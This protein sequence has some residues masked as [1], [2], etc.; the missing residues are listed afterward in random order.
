MNSFSN[1][2]K[3]A[4]DERNI[5]QTDLSGLTGISKAS[6][7]Q[8]LSGKNEPSKKNVAKITEALKVTEAW[9]LGID[10]QARPVQQVQEPEPVQPVIEQAKKITV[11]E[12]A[13]IMG[14]A[15]KFVRLG[16]QQGVFPFGSAVKVS[17]KWSYYISP[18]KFNDYIGR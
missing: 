8:Y 18:Q 17:T 15:D 16:L 1:R 14:K 4:M 13:R 12:A 11:E 3:S 2:L 7:S 6:I 10:D 5:N 9:L